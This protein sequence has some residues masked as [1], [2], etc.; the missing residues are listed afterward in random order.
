MN[1]DGILLTLLAVGGLAICGL[2]KAVPDGGVFL[3]IVMA[4]AAVVLALDRL[5]AWR[6]W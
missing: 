4:C 3:L 5:C 6:R 1:G 2:R